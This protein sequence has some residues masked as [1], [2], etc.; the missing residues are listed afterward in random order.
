MKPRYKKYQF[1]K[2]TFKSLSWLRKWSSQYLDVTISVLVVKYL[3]LNLSWQYFFWTMFETISYNINIGSFIFRM[4]NMYKKKYFLNQLMIIC[5]NIGLCLTPVFYDG[6]T[7][8]QKLRKI[9]WYL[10]KWFYFITFY[11]ILKHR[12]DKFIPF[13]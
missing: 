5:S 3:V 12:I 7:S 8:M 1:T 13:F 10:F 9:F 2:I 4:L 11:V 6:G